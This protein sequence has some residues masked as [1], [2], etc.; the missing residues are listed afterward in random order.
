MPLGIG[1][2]IG[3]SFQTE[4]FGQ[5]IMAALEHRDELRNKIAAQEKERNEKFKN[6]QYSAYL[7][8]IRPNYDGIAPILKD[9]YD[10]AYLDEVHALVNIFKGSESPADM[11]GGFEEQLDH[12][13]KIRT[14]L[15][16]ASQGWNTL[17]TEDPNKL[18]PELQDL[19]KWYRNGDY[20]GK[21]DKDIT[22]YM[23]DA[24]QKSK[25]RNFSYDPHNMAIGM[26]GVPQ[27]N[28]DE[29]GKRAKGQLTYDAHQQVI[30]ADGYKAVQ[31]FVSNKKKDEVYHNLLASNNNIQEDNTRNWLAMNSDDYNNPENWAVGDNGE[32]LRDPKTRKAIPSQKAM[33]A[34]KQYAIGHFE[35]PQ[36]QNDLTSHPYIVNPATSNKIEQNKFMPAAVHPITIGEKS[37]QGENYA[38]YSSD[39]KLNMPATTEAI[40]LNSNDNTPEKIDPIPDAMLI[41]TMRGY[42]TPKGG[43]S[44]NSDGGKNKP[45]N[46]LAYGTE[47]SVNTGNTEGQ[48]GFTANSKKS[49]H[50]GDKT[51]TNAYLVPF[52]AHQLRLQKI[53]ILDPEGF[54]KAYPD[55][56]N[57]TQHNNT[58][59]DQIGTKLN[60]ASFVEGKQY[61]DGE[62]VKNRK[63][64]LIEWS[65]IHG[66]INPQ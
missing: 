11:T 15:K 30:G 58:S 54:Y 17:F 13:E 14:D 42:R 47:E 3:A 25:L 2:A 26:A 34:F 1:S 60:P 19:Q 22:A 44:D 40:S 27:I 55:Q 62:I 31:H 37:Y 63:G 39:V 33:D 66:W 29:L 8:A 20:V 49:L 24:L 57:N 50:L 7:Q 43:Y 51:F 46:W 18:D 52:S 61:K 32:V 4:D 48:S 59:N 45:T 12:A 53:D 16:G 21:S 36:P 10:K 35:V 28:W 41:Y 65:D 6:D 9:K 23:Q 56:E 38:E 64:K 5:S